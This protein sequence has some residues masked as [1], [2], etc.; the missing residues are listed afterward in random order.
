[1]KHGQPL[2][3]FDCFRIKS[4]L[5][6]D[7]STPPAKLLEKDFKGPSYDRRGRGLICRPRHH[8]RLMRTLRNRNLDQIHSRHLRT[9]GAVDENLV[10]AL[11]Q[12]DGEVA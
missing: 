1:M 4:V 3:H 12:T 2:R 7:I 5:G 6:H 10:A 9:F 11:G 8:Q